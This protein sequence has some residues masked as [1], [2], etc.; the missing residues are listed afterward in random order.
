[1]QQVVGNRFHRPPFAFE[2]AHMDGFDRGLRARAR[3]SGGFWGSKKCS[4]AVVFSLTT[5]SDCDAA[6]SKPGEK[7]DNHDG[8][9]DS[10][11]QG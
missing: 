8:A 1:M 9:Y 7:H 6:L 5:T 2:L 4:S 10:L 3:H 11:T